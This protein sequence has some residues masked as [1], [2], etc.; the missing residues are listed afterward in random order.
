MMDLVVHMS[1]LRQYGELINHVVIS[2]AFKTLCD[3]S[4]I[5]EIG[6]FLITPEVTYSLGQ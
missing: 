2:F 1:E 5:I 6:S 4:I 3:F